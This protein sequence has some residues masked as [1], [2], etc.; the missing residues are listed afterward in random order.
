MPTEI[1][2]PDCDGKPIAENT[3]QFG[4]IVKVE[5]GSER[6]YRDDPDVFVAGDLLWYPVEG[7]PD[8]RTAP[9]AMVAIGRPKGDRR[10]YRQWVEGGIPPQVVFEILAPASG[11][12]EMGSKFEFYDRYAVQEYYIYD[13][14]E[15][16]LTGHIRLGSDLVRIPAM[17]GWTSPILGVRFDMS[18][19]ELH[20][21]GPDGNRFLTYQET[22]DER[23]QLLRTLKDLERQRDRAERDWEQAQLCREPDRLDLAERVREYQ[24]TLARNE[25]LAAQLRAMRIEPTE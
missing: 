5:A 13:P 11:I 4:W 17:D 1:V 19:A 14:D 9:D 23:D 7:R 6:I 22:A 24:A 2:Y 3:L 8:I 20:L 12:V 25:R 18:V 16:K 21:F 15:V 10:S